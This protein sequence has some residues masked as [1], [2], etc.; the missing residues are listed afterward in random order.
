M[1]ERILVY[2]LVRWT[3][4]A[5]IKRVSLLHSQSFCSEFWCKNEVLN[6]KTITETLNFVGANRNKVIEWMK[7]LLPNTA[8]HLI[9]MD[10][11]HFF[12]ASEN[13][14]INEIGHNPHRIFDE[15]IRLMYM[16]STNFKRPVYFRPLNG[17]ITDITALK[18]CISVMC[19]MS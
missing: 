12:S 9:L 18:Q 1:A 17:N 15:Q 3:F 13:V 5:P 6:D 4:R 16:F 11:S 10:S 14:T 2:A 8:E 19:T 7:K